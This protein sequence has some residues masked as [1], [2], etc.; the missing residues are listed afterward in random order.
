MGTMKNE[1]NGLRVVRTKNVEGPGDTIFV[2]LPRALWSVSMVGACQCAH[3][4]AV[5]GRVAYWDTLA[6]STREGSNYTWTVH[7]PEEHPERFQ[8]DEKEVE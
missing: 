3:C 5:P 7:R 8:G 6:V 1:L 4:R 2:P